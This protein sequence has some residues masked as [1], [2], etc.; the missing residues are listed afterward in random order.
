VEE[1]LL[2]EEEEEGLLDEDD[3]GVEGFDE[4]D[5]GGATEVVGTDGGVPP[6]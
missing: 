4:E 3:E 5:A 6:V 2:D 1:V